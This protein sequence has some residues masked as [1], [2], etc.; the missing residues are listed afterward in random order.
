M[1]LAY[2]IR[3]RLKSFSPAQLAVLSFLML[4][5][6]GTGLLLLPFSSSSGDISVID[7]LFTSTS[8]VCVTGLAV[9]DTGTD[10]SRFGQLSILTLIQLGG[11]GMMVWSGGVLFLLGGSLGL[12][13]RVLLS[14][15]VPR[16]ELSQMKFLIRGTLAFTIVCELT[17]ALLLWMM[18]T[19]RLG[20]FEAAYA[21]AFHSISAFCNA[22]FSLW[23]DSL[24]TDVEHLGVNLV[25]ALLIILG[26]L[27]YLVVLELSQRKRKRMSLHSRV[28]LSVTAILVVSGAIL[29][30]L[31]EYAN[32]GTLATLS[33][34]GRFI[35]SVFQSVTTRTA[36][37]NT[38]DIGS[39]YPSTQQVMMLYMFVGACPGSTAGGLKVTTFAVLLV[40]TWNYL[41]GKREMSIWER[42]L[43]S[44]RVVQALALLGLMLFF[45]W[46]GTISLSHLESFGLGPHLFEVVS[47]VATVGLSTGITAKLSFYSKLVVCLLMFVGRVGPLTLALALTN[48]GE[49]TR[50]RYVKEDIGLG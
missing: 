42:R 6:F 29:F 1:R 48:G 21:A 36:G 49:R 2:Q 30:Y 14:A 32:P 3:T 13:E 35:A 19:P 15:Q 25:V 17:G 47:A 37:F 38:V 16:L 26:G 28:A 46:L 9:L 43:P 12:R 10:F 7:A 27:G 31:L 39:C 22:G 24:S 20:Y 5:L 33:P 40:A 34:E 11:L 41:Q 8:A 44:E 45:V 18:W 50:I 4:I 23:S